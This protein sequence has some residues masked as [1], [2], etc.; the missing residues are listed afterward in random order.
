MKRLGF[1]L[2]NRS[3]SKVLLRQWYAKERRKVPQTL[4][5]WGSPRLPRSRPVL[6]TQV[7]VRNPDGNFLLE[8]GRLQK[9]SSISDRNGTWLHRVDC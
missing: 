7:S 1:R 4:R 9:P 2:N 5:P 3:K 8:A 6:Q